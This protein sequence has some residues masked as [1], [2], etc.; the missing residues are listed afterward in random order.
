MTDITELAQSLKNA[1]SKALIEEGL[2]ERHARV[3]LRLDKDEKRCAALQRIIQGR[4]NVAQS[5][6]LVEEM[7]EEAVPIEKRRRPLPLVRD[8]RL[9]FNTVSNA[10]DTMRR[11]GIHASA[12][13][14]ET[15]EYI[16]YLVRIPKG[17]G[18]AMRS[19][20]EFP[21]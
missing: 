20:R 12:Q 18:A 15:E 2:T 6:R 13:K 5:E 17:A 7:L 11:S 4:L 8:V 9:F 21:A 14:T 1:A 3:L 19:G 10:V 16:E